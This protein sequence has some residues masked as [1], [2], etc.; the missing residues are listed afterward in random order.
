MDTRR[1]F[2]ARTIVLATVLVALLAGLVWDGSPLASLVLRQAIAIKFGDMRHVTPSDLA[3]WMSDP[4]RP[5]PLLVDARPPA[6]FAVSH[7]ANA[8]AIDPAQPD[9]APIARV[10][11]D[12]P[13]V[14]Y[15]GPGV[16][17]AAM[18]E[19][20]IQSG[21]TRVSLLD[22]GL[23]RW[24]NEGHPLEGADGAAGKVH[25]VS[26]AWGRLLKRRHRF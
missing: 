24:A 9:L 22:G 23:F 15:D 1:R 6:Q 14:I 21:Y 11:K 3:A 12:H 26:W 10:P 8:V 16:V 25:P 17:A 18:G 7:I 4:N 5:P 2:T 13:L 19:A 20:L